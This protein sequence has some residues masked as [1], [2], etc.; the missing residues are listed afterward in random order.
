MLR[1]YLT[2]VLIYMIIIFS[3]VYVGQYKIKEN[4]WLDDKKKKGN[5]F[6]S[7]F[8]LSAIPILRMAVVAAMFVMIAM[9]KE[10][11][12]RFKDDMN[13]ESN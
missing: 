12:E 8:C 13:N 11:C 2:S 6:I 10:E 1:V 5:A 7:L 4:G 9:T 3:I